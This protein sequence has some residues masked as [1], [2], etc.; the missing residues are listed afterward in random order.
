MVIYLKPNN[1]FVKNL[2]EDQINKLIHLKE[3]IPT[4]IE[5]IFNDIIPNFRS[6]RSLNMADNLLKLEQI[7][8][9]N[10]RNMTIEES[11]DYTAKLAFKFLKKHPEFED[12]IEKVVEL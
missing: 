6:S 8:N 11:S 3:P 2:S 7:E 9:G 4:R 5:N 10:K 12:M 1:Q